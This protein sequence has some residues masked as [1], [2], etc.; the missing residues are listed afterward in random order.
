MDTCNQGYQ[1]R[2]IKLKTGGSQVLNHAQP[3]WM[4]WYPGESHATGQKQFSLACLWFWLLYNIT[5]FLFT[6]PSHTKFLWCTFPGPGVPQSLPEGHWLEFL[7]LHT[8]KNNQIK[9]LFVKIYLLYRWR[10]QGD[11]FLPS[12]PVTAQG[13][14]F[15]R[16]STRH[17]LSKMSEKTEEN[18]SWQA[19]MPPVIMA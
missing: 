12:T 18:R 11:G 4:W 6:L 10:Y 7:Y 16:V 19:H 15:Q 8:L 14:L 13:E 1:K 3:C 9:Q 17:I 5:C 2:L